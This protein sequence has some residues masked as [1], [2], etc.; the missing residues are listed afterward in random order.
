MSSI[1]QVPKGTY[2]RWLPKHGIHNIF[3]APMDNYSIDLS[4][5]EV[6]DVVPRPGPK[7]YKDYVCWAKYN[8]SPRAYLCSKG[9]NSSSINPDTAEGWIRLTDW[10]EVQAAEITK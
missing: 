9:E 8:G 5:L 1:I 6:V 7:V 3:R 2:Y 4:K 10:I